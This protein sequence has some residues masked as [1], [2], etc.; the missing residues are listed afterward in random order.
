MFKN[1]LRL[2][3]CLLLIAGLTNS[4][5]T[6][7][8]E[9]HTPSSTETQKTES[10]A[11]CSADLELAELCPEDM[12]LMPTDEV[13]GQLA[14][15]NWKNFNSSKDK[16]LLFLLPDL[17]DFLRYIK[18]T[19]D[20]NT[21]ICF[22]SRDCYFL[23]QLYG[24]MYPKDNNHEYVYASRK[25]CYSGSN[26][27]KKYIRNILD[28]RDKTLWVDIQGS[29]DSHVY[30][31][32]ENFDT[33]PPKL[34]FKLNDLQGQYTQL[35]HSKR[36]RA[37]KMDRSVYKQ[38]ITSFKTKGWGVNIGGRDATQGAFYLESLNRAPHPSVIN[39]DANYNPIYDKNYEYM[40]SNLELLLTTYQHIL[41]NFWASNNINLRTDSSKFNLSQNQSCQKWNGIL[42]LDV[43]ETVTHD[44]YGLLNELVQYGLD[45][46]IKIIFI[47]ARHNPFKGN[48]NGHLKDIIAPFDRQMGYPVDI[49][50]NP[51]AKN[52]PMSFVSGIKIQQLEIARQELGLPKDKCMLVDNIFMTIDLAK[53]SGFTYSTQVSTSRK[54]GV[55]P[56]TL[57]NIKKMVS[58]KASLAKNSDRQQTTPTFFYFDELP[59]VEQIEEQIE[60]A[61]T[62][63]R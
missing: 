32:K 15:I 19:T 37:P 47:T 8:K 57:K 5:S 61:K 1:F 12:H 7:K 34:F 10:Q 24:K 9:K 60:P 22:L 59:N 49:W 6:P 20:E 51:F 2:P 58:R 50:Y 62:L 39:M 42:A 13:I 46:K 41:D 45:N 28:K 29:G 53:K 33:V 17:I 44:D 48:Y 27:Y 63:A 31:F 54:M 36:S 30:F 18:S 23:D 26:H 52:Q 56:K 25:I 3:L 14:R 38:T 21:H 4:C 16:F 35:S 11:A 40:D 43:D 55:N